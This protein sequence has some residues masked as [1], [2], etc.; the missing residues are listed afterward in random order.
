[1]KRGY[2]CGF[3]IVF[4]VLLT[5]TAFAQSVSDSRHVEAVT[6]GMGRKFCRGLVNAVTGVGEIPRQ[7][8]R[9]S[10]SD[11]DWTGLGRGFIHGIVMTVIRTGAGAIETGLFFVPMR[12]GAGN[13]YQ[14]DYG[15][16][17]LPVYVWDCVDAKHLDW[18]GR[19]ISVEATPP[20]PSPAH[21]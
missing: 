12:Q 13:V 15:P 6:S 10:Q 1:M 5:T 4:A 17:L 14:L 9:S 2:V 16:I 7:M 8:I 3:A 11:G 18:C 20:C 19:P 21:Q